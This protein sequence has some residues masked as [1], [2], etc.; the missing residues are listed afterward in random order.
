MGFKTL[1]LRPLRVAAS[2]FDGQSRRCQGIS[3]TSS[4]Q[5]NQFCY[6]AATEQ[7]FDGESH[8]GFETGVAYCEVARG[9]ESPVKLREE[10]NVGRTVDRIVNTWR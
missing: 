7:S 10:S 3:L 5:G 8:A 4:L 1:R 6:L 9:S 2:A